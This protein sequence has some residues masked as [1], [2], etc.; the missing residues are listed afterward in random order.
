MHH[1]YWR[2]R[3]PCKMVTKGELVCSICGKIDPPY[4]VRIGLDEKIDICYICADDINKATYC[5]TFHADEKIEP[6]D[7]CPIPA[8]MDV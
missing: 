7:G 6:E 5:I 1:E 8:N 2:T 4:V 3:I